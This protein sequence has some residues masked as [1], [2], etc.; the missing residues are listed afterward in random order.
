MK[1]R[2]WPLKKERDE[3]IG[4]FFAFALGWLF[5]TFLLY[6]IYSGARDL[7]SYLNWFDDQAKIALI[8]TMAF[9]WSYISF[10]VGEKEKRQDQWKQ[11]IE[12]DLN[13][14]AQWLIEIDPRFDYEKQLMLELEE[15]LDK[16]LKEKANIFAGA[17][18]NALIRE[19]E[20]AGERTLLDPLRRKWRRGLD[21]QAR[22]NE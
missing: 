7:A 10:E 5:L 20:E 18:H 15:G 2:I 3:I 8:A 21:E 12:E 9:V 16:P 22:K 17:Q 11:D 13:E 14:V 4:S 1:S 6:I 19:K